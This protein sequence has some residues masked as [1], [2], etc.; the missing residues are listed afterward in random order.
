M[1]NYNERGMLTHISPSSREEILAICSEAADNTDSPDLGPQ[2]VSRFVDEDPVKI[3]LP[4]R[5]TTDNSEPSTLAES[6]TDP[7]IRPTSTVPAVKKFEDVVAKES[8]T[9][10]SEQSAKKE[11]KAHIEKKAEPRT[12]EPTPVAEPEAPAQTVKPSLKRKSREEEEVAEGRVTKPLVQISAAPVAAQPQKPAVF[13]DRP[14]NR[15]IKELPSL[16]KDGRGRPKNVAATTGAQRKPLG[17]K[18][19]NENLSSPKKASTKP[20]V[21]DEV[22]KAKSDAKRDEHTK[23]RAEARKEKGRKEAPAVI[24]I[25]ASIPEPASASPV[26]IDIEPTPSS[27]AEAPAPQE[28]ESE[29]KARL[30]ATPAPASPTPTP[31]REEVRDTPPPLD[32]SSR[33]E[34]TRGSR[35]TR[36]TVSYAEPN[37]RDKM[38]RPTKQLFDAVAG[39]GKNQMQRRASSQSAKSSNDLPTPASSVAPSSVSS[40]ATVKAGGRG[41]GGEEVRMALSE[42]PASPLAQKTATR[43]SSTVVMEPEGTSKGTAVAN[44][45]MGPP[46]PP[47]SKSTNRRLDEIAAREAEVAKMFD[48]PDDTY[49]IRDGLSPRRGDTTTTTASSSR[50]GRTR[51]LSSMAREDHDAGATATTAARNGASS[52]S[53]KRASMMAISKSKMGVN[54]DP[55]VAATGHDSSSLEGDSALTAS[56]TDPADGSAA[57][58]RAAST[59]RRSMML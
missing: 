14:V 34:T 30:S 35:R 27:Q 43:V 2:P 11:P 32:I 13:K 50:S 21:V 44:S 20:N 24:D 58:E 42:M 19:T 36:M 45:T 6:A 52:N 1:P 10:K 59:R 23:N 12:T 53:R 56:S 17:A 7:I 46:P 40:S 15:P 8:Q 54:D 29:P 22:N 37:L 33:G 57:R 3:D 9:M 18:T 38:R 28:R 51:R 47:S 4:V 16:K 26:P 48:G 31:L 5:A 25:P 39:E 49:E 55:E 41:R